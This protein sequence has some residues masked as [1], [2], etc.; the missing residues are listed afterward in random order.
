MALRQVSGANRSLVR[1]LPRSSIGITLLPPFPTRA[2]EILSCPN[3]ANAKTEW[4]LALVKGDDAAA[5]AA[6]IKLVRTGPSRVNLVQDIPEIYSRWL[7]G[8]IIGR[9]GGHDL[10]PDD[11]IQLKYTGAYGI[12]H[13]FTDGKIDWLYNPT[14]T[15]GDKLTHEWQVQLNRHYQWIPLCKAWQETGDPKYAKAFENELRSWVSQ[16]PR[17]DDNGMGVPGCWRLIEVGIRMGWTWPTA[18]ETFR[19][20]EHVSDEAIWLMISAMHE[21]A[22]H[23]L[24]WPT[25]RNFKTMESNGLLHVAAMFPEFTRSFAFYSTA[26][27]RVCT[28]LERQVYPDGSQDELAPSYGMVAL[29]NFHSAIQMAKKFP[30]ASA[31]IPQRALDRINDSA[32]ALVAIAN[33]EAV[34]PPIHDSPEHDI[35]GLYEDFK[36]VNQSQSTQAS[37]G[38][39]DTRFNTKPWLVSGV[40][41][42]PWAG[43]HILRRDGRY[44]LFD[45][46]PWG[47]GHQHSDALQ[48]LTHAHGKW[49]C[50]DPG[51]PLYNRSA[52]TQHIRSSAGHNVV[53]LDGQPHYPAPIEPVAQA[54][55]P[56]A[57]HDHGP[58]WATAA[59]RSAATHDIENLDT[60]QPIAFTH[61]R[62]VLDI[63]NLGWL[64]VDRMKAADDQP[65][66]WEGLWHFSSDDLAVVNSVHKQ[67]TSVDRPVE[68]QAGWA[69]YSDGPGMLILP[70]ALPEVAVA[71]EVLNGQTDPAHRGWRS[72]GAGDQPMPSPVLSTKTA[73][74]HQQVSLITLLVPAKNGKHQPVMNVDHFSAT[75]DRID[76]RFSHDNQSYLFTCTGKPLAD[77]ELNEV[78]YTLPDGTFTTFNLAPHSYKTKS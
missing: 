47:T 29:S 50:I 37:Q 36:K 61:E 9:Q 8:F 65:H 62:L 13:T 51:K 70:L 24:L 58:V 48:L 69:S 39:V 76:V 19:S 49:F 66:H 21:H 1:T 27:D 56:V 33:P 5:K 20:C 64:V 57:V 32:W 38:N 4:E 67:A 25:K 17:P 60:H 10:E 53:L 63:A 18:L 44:S 22:M 14:A 74:T 72:F 77:G 40:T 16:C 11:V 35:Q 26:L 6:F 59:C 54:P 55:Y 12:Q 68:M 30:K 31:E 78:N 41:S 46:G 34:L 43:W 42:L 15:W 3:P 73:P 71:L 7:Q 45:A 75:D 28:E 23:L 2:S 52:T